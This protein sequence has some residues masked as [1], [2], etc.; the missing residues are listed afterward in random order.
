MNLYLKYRPTEFSQIVGNQEVVEYLQGALQKDPPHTFLLHGQTGCGKTTI[1]R[2]IANELGCSDEDYKEIDFA[3]F[4]GIETVRNIIR[5]SRYQPIA[6]DSTVWV[7]DEAHKM[8]ND[9]QNAF[10][11]LLEEPP[12]HSYFVLCT[13]EPNKLLKT[14]RGRC[15]N[16]PVYPLDDEDMHTLLRRVVKGEGERIKRSVYE[17]IIGDSFG[18]PR[19]ALQTLQRVLAVSPDK[20]EQIARES[21]EEQSQSIEL[22]RSLIKGSNWKIVSGILNG[23]K[24]QDAE[25]IRRHVLAYCQSV[26]LSKDNQDAALIMEE[27]IE[28]FYNSGFPGLVLA[29]YSVTKGIEE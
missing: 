12:T 25:S 28:P 4:R 6:G 15:I 22:C 2:I 23:L 3:D 9:A 29:C 18:L 11:K 7:I 16:L 10:L 1:A 5:N 19:N 27:F 14:I 20:Q 26:L 24:D 21:A 17:Q 8:T 13:T